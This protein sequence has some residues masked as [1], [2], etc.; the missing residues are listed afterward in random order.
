M[1][2]RDGLAYAVSA[3]WDS[4]PDHQG[5]FLA[6]GDTSR[7]V[8]LLAELRKV[9]QGC[10]DVPPSAAEL[11]QARAQA[12]NSFVF[13]FSSGALQLQRVLSY[14][15]LGLPQDYLFRW[16]EEAIVGGFILAGIFC[17]WLKVAFQRPISKQHSNVM[18][19][20][21]GV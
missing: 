12:L 3:G 16:V 4:P 17:S 6:G 19:A 2:S 10:R 9:L 5:L 11:A 21:L 18:W 7:P 1:R 20:C 14:S 15:L 8:E 13:N